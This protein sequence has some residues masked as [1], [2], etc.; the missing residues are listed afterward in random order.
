MA[1]AAV[2]GDDSVPTPRRAATRVVFL[3]A[4]SLAFS[5]FTALGVWQL[6]RLQWKQDLIERVESRIHAEPVALPA[7]SEW[8]HVNAARDE[9]KH[10][11]L[12]GHFIANMD[13][14]VQALT[15][16]G[17]GFWVL[18][19]F[20]L[21]DGNVV[22]VN[23]GYVPSAEKA[24]L[25]LSPATSIT[26]LLR[27]SEAG[28]GFLRDNA[29][30]DNRWYSRDVVAIADA[31]GL[32]NVAPFFVDADAG[33]KVQEWPRGGLTVTRFSNNHLGY[34]LT[35]F[36]LALLCAWAGWYVMIAERKMRRAH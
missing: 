13:T 1:G 30:A 4:L 6:Y 29:P 20:R 35:W 24:E 8:S 9:Y 25:P 23:R 27:L 32:V 31:R 7:T 33:D 22:L 21:H 5:G 10:V 19:P 16:L 18:S 17:A 26:G 2:Q 34:A 36:A 14:R 12:E 15:V 3:M 28:G 11:R